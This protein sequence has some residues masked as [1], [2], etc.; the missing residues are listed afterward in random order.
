MKYIT[1]RIP[2][3]HFFDPD[4]VAFK[5]RCYF[6]KIYLI[7]RIM[8]RLIDTQYF[9]HLIFKSLF[10]LSQIRRKKT[11]HTQIGRKN[12]LWMS[13]TLSS[14]EFVL[15]FETKLNETKTQTKMKNQ[16]NFYVCHNSLL[17]FTCMRRIWNQ[18]IYFI[19]FLL[20]FER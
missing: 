10:H 17:Q 7:L 1:C 11:S 5:L 8:S 20:L 12:L 16:Q 13:F 15:K 6:Y 18:I 9:I 2:I 14:C 19:F 4:H 3:D